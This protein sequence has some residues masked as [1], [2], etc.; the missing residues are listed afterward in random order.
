MPDPG[1]YPP[2]YKI[3]LDLRTSKTSYEIMLSTKEQ[4]SVAGYSE[5]S[6]G[7]VDYDK[8]LDGQYG[9]T[10]NDNTAK[11]TGKKKLILDLTRPGA[12][13]HYE[14]TSIADEDVDNVP[15]DGYV[16]AIN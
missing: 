10:I 5:R 1:S 7:T 8:P 2:E 9:A 11:G 13:F 4:N 3:K 12:K 16:R 15:A 6:S 14:G